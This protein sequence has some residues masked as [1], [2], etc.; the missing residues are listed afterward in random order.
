[1]V[2]TKGCAGCD[3][4]KSLG[5]HGGSGKARMACHY[6]LDTGHCRSLIC[7]P[8][9]Q[10]TVRSVKGVLKQAR[11]PMHKYDSA[12]SRCRKAPV[13]EFK[14]LY[15]K[16]LFD[17]QIAEQTGAARSTVANWRL[18]L[19]LRS[20]RWLQKQAIA[21]RQERER[22]KKLV[23]K[24]AVDPCL[25]CCS[26]EVCQKVGGTCNEKERWKG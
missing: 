23:E 3:H 2:D 7:P 9:S 12:A 19:G 1:M 8:G 21:K 18:G 13:E 24:E 15:Q 26:A 11:A 20:N 17:E 16:G 22:I 4:W 6:S 10:C 25:R 14:K 5:W